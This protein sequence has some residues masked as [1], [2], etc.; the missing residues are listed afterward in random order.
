MPG[1][2]GKEGE[3]R[4]APSERAGWPQDPSRQKRANFMETEEIVDVDDADDVDSAK[5]LVEGD[6]VAGKAMGEGSLLCCWW[7]WRW[8]LW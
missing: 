4:L 1:P 2:N 7:G 8:W 5:E 6:H 3:A